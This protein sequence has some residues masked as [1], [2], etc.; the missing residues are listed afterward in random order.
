M[1]GAFGVP[2]YFAALLKLIHDIL[3]FLGPFLLRQLL[4]FMEQKDADIMVGVYYA[5]GLF[6]AALLQSY[7]LRNY[8][9]LCFRT[10]MRMRSTVVTMVYNK[11]LKLSSTA[12]AKYTTGEITNFMEVDSQ[13]F[14]DLTSYLQTLW[15]GPFQIIV[16]LVMLYWNLGWSFITGFIL[17]LIMIPVSKALSKKLKSIQYD[18]MKAKDKR[19]QLTG[20]VVGG[21][22]VIKLQAWERAFLERLTG[23]RGVEMKI[24]RRY[25]IWNTFNQCIWN[26]VPVLVAGGTFATYTLTGGVLTNPIAFTSISLFNLLRFPVTMFPQTMNNISEASNSVDR[27]Q[28]FLLAEEQKHLHIHPES[29]EKGIKLEKVHFTWPSPVV[30]NASS[31]TPTESFGLS[32][33]SLNIPMNFLAGITGAVGCGKSS[34]INGIL[35]E[36]EIVG[37]NIFLGGKVAYVP[38]TSYILNDTLRNNIL[39]NSPFNQER[40]DAVIEA[41][42]LRPDLDILPAGDQT[43]IGEKGINLSGGQKVRVSLARAVYQDS[44]IYILD[45]PLSAVDAHVSKHIFD[46]CINGILKG[47]CILL[48]THALEYLKYCDSI[49]VMKD[50]HIVEQGTWNH[51]IEESPSVSESQSKGVLKEL[52]DAQLSARAQ[53]AK[54][55][56]PDH[57]P[58]SPTPL[59]IAEK[60]KIN[61]R[62]NE[63][64]ASST[65]AAPGGKLIQK[66]DRETGSVGWRIYKQYM[67]ASGGVNW[68]IL[69]VSMFVLSEA[70]RAFGSYWITFWT[71]NQFNQD[72]SFYIWIYVALGVL[73]IIFLCFRSITTFFTGIRGSKSL[74]YSVL[75]NILHLPMLFFDTTPQGRII[76]RFSK[77]IYIVDSQLPNTI[78]S[79]FNSLMSVLSTVIIISI[80]T[81]WFLIVLIFLSIYYF[82]EQKVFITSSREI[83]RLDS[84]SR[85]PIYAHF[86]ETLDGIP[87]IRAFRM[88]DYFIN[89]NNKKLDYNQ[90]A[91]F[92]QFSANCW[93]GLRLEFAG[94]IIVLF[95]SL[96]AVLGKATSSDDFVGIAALSISYA[97]SVTQNL[98]WVVRMAADMETQIVAVERINNYAQLQREAPEHIEGHIPEESWPSRGDITFKNMSMRYRQELEPVLHHI[99][100]SIKGEEK[101]GVVGRTGAGKSSLMLALMRIIELDEGEIDIDN[102][103]ISEIGLHDLRSRIA[104]ISQEPVLFSG[105]IREN[106]DPFDEYKD[107]D[108]WIALERAHM[109][110]VIASSDLGLSSMV[111]EHGNNYSVGQRQ[112]LCIARALLHHTKIILMD[113]ATA[114][115]DVETDLKIQK[116]MKEE[117]KDCTVI[118]IAHRIHTIIDSD[119]VMVLEA[120]EVK[121]F[122]QPALLLEDPNTIFSG[123]VNEWK[124]ENDKKN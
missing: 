11:A 34:L 19:L 32:D 54:E 124:Q 15:S 83:K 17:I 27:V 52:Y 86:S 43:E 119:K 95:S 21:I 87:V 81:P 62:G 99:N 75:D 35:G 120:G 64:V 89:N 108:I 70:A 84:I 60:N 41:C 66:E 25:A 90:R 10:G 29:T 109:K 58:V 6:V 57:T 5:L 121:E 102:M 3:Q 103:N 12:R 20:E 45:D 13:R 114:S 44:D 14:Q 93:L 123:L 56:T 76:N 92:L 40:Y 118:T 1:F 47:K 2:F 67:N 4:D 115:I 96:L 49:F 74:H 37:G 53:E 31:P 16:C 8:F 105:T 113:E 65:E 51:L 97:L 82:Y 73:S 79:F 101:V 7:C 24:L 36:M 77:D 111:E 50:G 106:I 98:N 110:D 71:K 38:Q 72:H 88:Q 30:K 107:S 91:Y 122:E 116:T 48:V 69:L 68:F 80:A 94:T 46:K 9:F 104:I 26:M 112:L 39:F 63:T 59:K 28:T 22:K 23:L 42:A 85:S 33:I 78:S 117:F 18:L 100:V 61:N 55:T